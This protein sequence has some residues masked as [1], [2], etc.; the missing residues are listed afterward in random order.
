M[1]C[2]PLADTGLPCPV[3]CSC[4][5]PQQANHEL[6]RWRLPAG[7]EQLAA[8]IH[9]YDEFVDQRGAAAA[10]VAQRRRGRVRRALIM[11]A[12]AGASL[13]LAAALHS[14]AEPEERQQEAAAELAAPEAAG[15]DPATL[16]RAIAILMRDPTSNEVVL[17]EL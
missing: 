15:P 6:T 4:A 3:V 7:V 16:Q 2:K 12:V 13:L 5:Q 9:A 8:R 10:E 1:G 17:V 14:A 11:G